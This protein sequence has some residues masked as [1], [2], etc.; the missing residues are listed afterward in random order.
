LPRDFYLFNPLLFPFFTQ[1][2]SILAAFLCGMRLL[3]SGCCKFDWENFAGK[4]EI[5]EETHNSSC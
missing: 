5:L 2:R 4:R 3:L 1:A